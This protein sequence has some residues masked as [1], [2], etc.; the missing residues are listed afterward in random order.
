MDMY[1]FT[2]HCTGLIRDFLPNATKSPNGSENTN[3]NTNIE[4][5]ASI[6]EPSCCATAI[7]DI[8]ILLSKPFLVNY[9]LC[10]YLR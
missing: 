10:S 5:D 8:S 9:N 2:S 4:S 1:N 7:N 6:P 3:V